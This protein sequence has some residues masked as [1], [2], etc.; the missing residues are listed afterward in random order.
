MQHR[1]YFFPLPQG[2]G[3]F[4]EGALI[5]IDTETASAHQRVGDWVG[6]RRRK[7]VLVKFIRE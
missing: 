3:S 5:G 4:R 7:R 2:Q 6:G 1:L